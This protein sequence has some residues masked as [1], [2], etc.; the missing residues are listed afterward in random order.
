MNYQIIDFN[1]MKYNKIQFINNGGWH[2]TNLRTPKEL[3]VKLK[4]F[5]HHAEYLESGLEVNDLEKM[6]KENRAVYDYSADMRK[7]KWSG[8]KKLKKTDLSE[9]PQFL[10]INR[11]K[12]KD[13]FS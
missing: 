9:L 1:K 5:G 4:N 3:E 2:F 7:D 12:Y 11:Q 6:I 10:Q 13:W 8:E